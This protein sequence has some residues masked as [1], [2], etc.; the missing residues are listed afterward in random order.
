LTYLDL[1]D[2]FEFDIMK[3]KDM[4]KENE[5]VIVSNIIFHKCSLFGPLKI[6]P[7]VFIKFISKIQAGYND[8]AYH[9]KTHAADVAQTYY[10][11]ITHCGLKEIANMDN[12]DIASAIISAGCHDYQHPG[13]NNQYLIETRSALAIRYNGKLSSLNCL[14]LSC[15]GES[16][17]SCFF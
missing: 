15:S 14:R 1:V 5:L 13:Y 3:L 6:N 7:E 8:V 11:F 12:L 4:T 17:F 10:Y 9:N 16:S 2:T